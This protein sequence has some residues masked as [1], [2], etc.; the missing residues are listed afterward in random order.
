M[1]IH[2]PNSAFL[3][4]IDSFFRSFDPHESNYLNITAN[5]KWISVHPLILTMIAALGQVVPT[6]AL[7]FEVLE[8]KSKHYF[9]RM[10]LFKFLKLNSGIS[11]TEHDQSG[12]FIPLTQIKDSASL[13]RFITEMIP[14]LHL[15]PTH[16]E[17]IRYIVSEL[18][19]NVIE[20]ADSRSGAFVAAQYYEKS[21]TIRIGICDVGVGI[22]KTIRRSHHATDDLQAIRLAITPGITGTT[23]REG[24]TAQNAGA[25]LFFVKSIAAVNGDFFVIYSGSAFY[26]LL[27]QNPKERHILHADPIKDRHSAKNTY[28]YWQG[29]AIGI[30]MKLDEHERFSALL[31]H[32]RRV[33]AKAVRERKQQQ[34]K[35]PIFI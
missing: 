13:T 4:N 1:K 2:L 18:V 7:K 17:P 14:L 3:G 33:Y 21:N 10:G 9:E 34:Y 16:V 28:P 29:T 27:R 35:R 11:M 31:E 23:P 15:S 8:A 6:D 26:K 5:K 19:R 24:G 20:H 30:D 12:R 32:I 22:T 25:G